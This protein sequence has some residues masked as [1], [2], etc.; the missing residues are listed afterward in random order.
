MDALRARA[1]QD[2]VQHSQE[3][4]ELKRKLDNETK[5][6]DFVGAKGA[7]RI[8]VDLEGA[9]ETKKSKKT[10]FS[11]LLRQIQKKREREK[12]QPPF[13]LAIDF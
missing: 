5:L 11:A 12:S 10:N 2:L 6:H 13:V 1:R 4:R 3:M 7:K 8:N 9:I